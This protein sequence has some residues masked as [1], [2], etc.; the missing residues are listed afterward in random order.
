MPDNE[1]LCSMSGI[2]MCLY[3]EGNLCSD[4]FEE[5]ISFGRTFFNEK[6]HFF[7]SI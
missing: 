1:P 3:G 4:K 2:F 5:A 7:N 6:Y